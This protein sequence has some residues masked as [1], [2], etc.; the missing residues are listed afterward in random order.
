MGY[1]P[2][3]HLKEAYTRIK[4]V[5]STSG[6]TSI[7]VFVTADADSLCALKILLR[8]FKSDCISYLV[9]PVAG[10]D[11]LSA[12]TEKHIASNDEVRSIIMINCGGIIDLESYFPLTD[13]MSVY[14][15]DSHRPI[16]L[17]NLFGG[18]KIIIF[19]DGEADN[20]KPVQEAFQSLEFDGSDDEDDEED[21]G[22]DFDENIGKDDDDDD[23]GPDGEDGENPVKKRK[24]N[25]NDAEI[26]EQDE[27]LL[28]PRSLRRKKA[29]NRRRKR[30][31][32]QEV[33]TSYYTEGSY[34]GS[35]ASSITYTLATQ[36]GKVNAEMLW[37]SIIGLTD[38]Y[39]HE[40]IDTTKYRMEASLLK[41]ETT[42]FDMDGRAAGGLGDD[43]NL[44]DGASAADDFELPADPDP[45][46]GNGETRR[47]RLLGTQGPGVPLLRTATA[48]GVHGVRSAH[49]RG[50][51]CVEEFR[52][53]LLRHWS[54]YESLYH[55][56]YVATRLGVWKAKG[57]QKLTNLLVKMG[58][59]YKECQQLFTEMH[60]TLKKD[61][62]RKLPAIG[63]AFNLPDLLFP[64]FL[65]HYGYKFTIGAGDAVHSL[66]ALLDC[67]ADWMRRQA[68]GEDVEADGSGGGRGSISEAAGGMGGGSVGGGRLG[69]GGGDAYG[70]NRGVGVAST[71]RMG[72]SGSVLAGVGMGTKQG[73][74]A[75]RVTTSEFDQSERDAKAL[76]ESGGRELFNGEM[77]RRKSKRG[78]RS[79]E[80]SDDDR[81]E[82]DSD[83]ED[84]EPAETEE[85]ERERVE[86]RALRKKKRARERE[87]VKNFYLAYD[88]LENVDLLYHGIHLSM[89]FQRAL[90]RAG[91][92]I[93]DR[94]ITKVLKAFRLTVLS[95]VSAEGGG[96]GSVGGLV[97]DN[98]FLVFGR[99]VPLL[100]R[101]ASFL[102]DA[103]R[104]HR[105]KLMPLVI[106]AYN[107]ETDGYLVLGVPDAK[108][109]GDVRKNFFG[110]AF[111]LA[112]DRT[113]AKLT[114]V[115]FDA[116]AAEVPR[117]DLLPFIE[118]LTENANRQFG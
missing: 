29:A 100:G 26:T 112:A 7:V 37:L 99:S 39:L 36:M 87:W 77:D 89:H 115:N 11:E 9:V 97:G 81:E 4:Q 104:E 91:I 72:G 2:L 92:S 10:L 41:D 75:L 70:G 95:G 38:Q 49:D 6:T 60:T 48:I 76:K 88:A 113:G 17:R 108:R 94:Q 46:G 20:M 30:R 5:A 31:G 79:G 19:D 58:F 24:L 52:L 93:L 64:S 84:D 21:A 85:A 96:G 101:L 50:I 73:T 65:R 18:D 59:P 98:E 8:L 32:Y 23:R 35:S 40:R 28:S 45:E 68:G 105:R 71:S 114:N 118:S 34:Y 106:A 107:D 42:R 14:V 1:V 47:H 109:S 74:A 117:D 82:G 13:Q 12:A 61:M 57:R 110:M 54:L 22:G 63:P 66:A 43:I 78:D 53:M 33:V 16:H 80:I 27:I 111:Q 44:D 86:R 103:Y 55:S 83:P 56:S 25:G 62:R 51:K 102:M 69:S 3:T 116:S 67:G 90:V 15:I